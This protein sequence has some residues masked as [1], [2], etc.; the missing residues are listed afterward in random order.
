MNKYHIHIKY[1]YRQKMLLL[2]SLFKTVPF[3]PLWL[4]PANGLADF[5]NL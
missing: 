3:P 2:I 1:L 5:R 4:N